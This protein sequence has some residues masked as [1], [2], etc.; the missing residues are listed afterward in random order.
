MRHTILAL[1]PQ[2]PKTAMKKR[3][4]KANINQYSTLVSVLNVVNSS[5]RFSSFA[6]MN[7]LYKAIK[8]QLTVMLILKLRR[9]AVTKKVQVAVL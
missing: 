7:S 9:E 6:A 5:L 4:P 8:F 2:V 3:K 1:V